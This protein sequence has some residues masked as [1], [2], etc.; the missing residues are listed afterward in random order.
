MKP[1][2]LII[3]EE[4]W[5]KNIQH[6]IVNL[7]YGKAISKVGGLPVVATSERSIDDYVKLADGLLLVDGPFVHVGAYGDYY[8][9]TNYPEL[10]RRREIMEFALIEKMIKEG[11]PVLGVNRGMR[12]INVFFGGT[13][14]DD[15][16]EQKIDR[17]GDRLIPVEF[18]ENNQVKS[19]VD[20]TKKVIGIK[21][22]P[23]SLDL[24][25]F[26]KLIKG[27]QK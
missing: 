18:D 27:A 9:T 25:A 19:F 3:A 26:E 23:N 8:K 17:L 4:G 24:D 16:E 5:A 15:G 12:L 14:C 1:K 2:I 20:D 22:S 10:H 7:D 6:F 13:L 11:K 21:C